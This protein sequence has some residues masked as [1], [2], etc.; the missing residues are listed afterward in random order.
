MITF[1]Q[2]LDYFSRKRNQRRLKSS[3]YGKRS[4]G[5][6]PKCKTC[7]VFGHEYAPGDFLDPC[8]EHNPKGKTMKPAC[9]LYIRKKKRK[10]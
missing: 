7:M 1:K 10:R 8:L 6:M 4:K 5:E 9:H 2:I 3:F